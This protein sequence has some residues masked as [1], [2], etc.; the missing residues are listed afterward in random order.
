M[1]VLAVMGVNTGVGKTHVSTLILRGLRKVRALDVL[2]FK[3][4][5][6]GVE[7]HDGVPQDA[8]RLLEA[9]GLPAALEDVCPWQ[10][11]RPVAPAAELERLDRRV[12]LQDIE[13]AAAA[14]VAKHSTPR[15]LFEGAGGVLSPLTWELD[16]THVA[17]HFQA[18]AWL[19]AKDELGAISQIRTAIEALDRRE[20][21]ILGVILN[22]FTD[23]QSIDEG[24]NAAALQR[25]GVSKVW[26]ADEHHVAASVIAES[27]V[28][29]R[30]R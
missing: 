10:L 16:A 7:D 15:L 23:E 3:P 28:W 12:S 17:R 4:F 26:S 8:A 1:R 22:R 18:A 21:P 24:K 6:S 29:Y 25:L 9:S 30:Q 13:G 20:I 2:P 19:V 14:L 5:E 27:S 11:P